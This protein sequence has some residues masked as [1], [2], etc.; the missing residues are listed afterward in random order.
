MQKKYS[1]IL[2]KKNLFTPGIFYL[3]LVLECVICDFMHGRIIDNFDNIAGQSDQL[4]RLV[5]LPACFL[6]C[7]LAGI[8][9]IS[10]RGRPAQETML[11]WSGATLDDFA[12]PQPYWLIAGLIWE[13]LNE[14]AGIC[15]APD[16]QIKQTRPAI[17][18]KP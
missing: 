11:N 9:G 12:S 7:G 6:I 15:N 16:L 4:S 1:E 2:C 10:G 18:L 17:R 8:E 5:R 14:S 3:S 13:G